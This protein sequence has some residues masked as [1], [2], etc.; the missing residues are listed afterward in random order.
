[1]KAVKLATQPTRSPVT[2]EKQVTLLGLTALHGAATTLN[3]RKNG[4]GKAQTGSA[5][6]K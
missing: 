1:M 6:R 5:P 2:R 4:S 3:E